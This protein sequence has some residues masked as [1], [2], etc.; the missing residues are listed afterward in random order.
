[1]PLW[2]QVGADIRRRCA[3]GEFADGVPGELSLREDY[4]VS[5]HTIREALREL[6][7]E[8]VIRSQRGRASS[9]RPGTQEDD[10]RRADGLAEPSVARRL[11]L[12]PDA[13]L[14]CVERSIRA[15]GRA[16]G[17]EARWL[18]QQ[19]ADA[20]PEQVDGPRIDAY[21]ETGA[22]GVPGER[23]AR[24]LGLGPHT[25]ALVIERLSTAL[26]RP[27]EWRVTHL[28]ADHFALGQSS[29]WTALPLAAS[30]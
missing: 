6:R 8:G 29:S 20:H 19:L 27:V 13:P 11:G 10:R 9:V 4:G 17:H 7:A 15:G 14:A 21:A 2:V 18:P 22:S 24:L 28:R 30:P 16:V 5:R 25:P 23:V 3:D 26:G 1:M 12:T